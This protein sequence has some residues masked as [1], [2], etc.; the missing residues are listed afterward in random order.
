[1][2]KTLK[3]AATKKNSTE[4]VWFVAMFQRDSFRKTVK[5]T[6]TMSVILKVRLCQECSGQLG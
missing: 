6:M 4:E 3:I 1:M 2:Q 5:N